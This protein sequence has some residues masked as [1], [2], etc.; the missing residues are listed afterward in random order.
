M[1]SNEELIAVWKSKEGQRFQNYRAMFCVLDAPVI[2]REWLNDLAH[3]S[4]DTNNAP[5]SLKKW[6]E[7]G[8]YSP[9][10]A[11]PTTITRQT[12]EQLPQTDNQ[13]GV[14]S[15]IWD[16]FK[17][18]PILFE[19]FSAYIYKMTDPR[20]TIQEITRATVDGGRDA[21]GHYQ[22]GIAS[23]P[24]FV[25]FALE[26]KCYN[27]G[28]EDGATNTVG[29]RETSR[30]ISRIRNRQFGVLVTTSAVSKQAYTEVRSDQHP[31][32][33]ICGKDIAEILIHN[34][35][36]SAEK[37]KKLLTQEFPR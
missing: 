34:G 29:V 33:F 16:Y 15:V 6:W 24:V 20:I 18:D 17:D 32:I 2:K 28:L 4:V 8:H 27:P 11:E 1:T 35:V 14:L 22:I 9:L 31:I 30:L 3:G 26:A 21:I 5:L 36:N 37:V 12:H 19:H 13:R 25:E 7:Q 10:K 23:D